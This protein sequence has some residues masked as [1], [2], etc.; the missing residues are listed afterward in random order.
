MRNSYCCT[1]GYPKSPPMPCIVHSPVLRAKGHIQGSVTTHHPVVLVT[2]EYRVHAVSIWRILSFHCHLELEQSTILNANRSAAS[3]RAREER[4]GCVRL[5]L[6]TKP[7]G[8]S[9]FFLS[10]AFNDFFS[11][12]LWVSFSLEVVLTSLS[13][14]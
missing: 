6:P 10:S 5:S 12:A 8:T 1:Y 13:L 3:S 14:S 11:Q 2:Y 9:L 4:S 7:K